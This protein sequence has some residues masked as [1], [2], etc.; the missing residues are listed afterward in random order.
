MQIA[1]RSHY[2]GE[3][4]ESQIGKEVVLCGWVNRRRDLGGVVFVDLRDRSGLVQVIYDPD[5]A[6]VF[7]RANRLRAEFCVRIS[8]LVR[9]RPDGQVNRDMATGAIEILGKQLEIISE[10]APLPVSLDE[11]LK[12]SEEQRLRFR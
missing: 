11:N 7:E 2:C 6:E 10:A 4:G 5:T 3:V 9:A 8:G 1:M 12:H